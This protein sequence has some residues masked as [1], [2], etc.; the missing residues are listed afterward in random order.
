MHEC[1]RWL[2]ANA[3]AFWHAAIAYCTFVWILELIA[4]ESGHLYFQW[5]YGVRVLFL[6]VGVGPNLLTF[7][8]PGGTLL[9]IGIPLPLMGESRSLGE[10]DDYE[11]ERGNPESLYYVSRNPLERVVMAA[12]G[13]LIALVALLAVCVAYQLTLIATGGEANLTVYIV[14]AIMGV[15]EL[16]NLFI[17]FAIPRLTRGKR[18]QRNDALIIYEGLWEWMRWKS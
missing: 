10:R 6:K 2:T 1:L 11:A 13:P 16:M 9:R 3:D 15:N 8:L 17:P 5:K 4:H 14:F 7:Q 18:W 12:A